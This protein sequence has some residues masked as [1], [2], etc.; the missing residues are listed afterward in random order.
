MSQNKGWVWDWSNFSEWFNIFK[1][2]NKTLRRPVSS[3]VSCQTFQECGRLFLCSRPRE[4]WWDHI[5]GSC[6]V[7]LLY[8]CQGVNLMM[9]LI[10]KQQQ[11]IKL[12]FISISSTTAYW[13]DKFP[14]WCGYELLRV[15][16]Q[17]RV[18]YRPLTWH[19]FGLILLIAPSVFLVCFSSF[20]CW[21]DD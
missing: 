11:N 18:I 3:E 17:I 8:C 15:K 12:S 13:P 14:W 20:S 19:T 10:H 5:F 2:S 4:K 6:F 16:G 7:L 1:V 9:I 21:G